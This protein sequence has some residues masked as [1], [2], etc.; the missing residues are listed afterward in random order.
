[1]PEQPP[2]DPWAVPTSPALPPA[3]PPYGAHR[4]DDEPAPADPFDQDAPHETHL[5]SD[6][7]H[8]S[9]S[10]GVD[11]VGPDVALDDDPLDDAPL[12]D[13]R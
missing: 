6:A 12:D 3:A 8:H 9:G 4:N 13:D 10:D 1:M 11:P 7:H 5:D 2:R